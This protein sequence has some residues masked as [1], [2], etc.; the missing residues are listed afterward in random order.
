MSCIGRFL[1]LTLPTCTG[2][3][4]HGAPSWKPLFNGKDFSGFYSWVDGRGKNNDSA[5]VFSIQDST[6][7]VYK[8]AVAGSLQPFAYLST[9]KEYSRYR[10][11]L[12]FKWGI[13]KFSPRQNSPRDAG[14]LFHIVLPDQDNWPRCT[15]FQ[16]IENNVGD[17]YAI[18]QVWVKSTVDPKSIGSGLTPLFM[19]ADQGGIPFE[20]PGFNSYQ[21]LIRSG[22]YEVAGWNDLELE[23]TDD[24]ATY[25]VNGHIVNRIFGIQQ[26][27]T[28]NPLSLKILNKGKIALQAEDAEVSYRHIEILDLL[29]T[30]SA[31]AIKSNSKSCQKKSIQLSKTQRHNILGRRSLKTNL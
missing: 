7:N 13:N 11:R 26:A 8:G 17:I 20:N 16:I 25:R 2:L 31:V 3:L 10:L 24:P 22:N 29:D 15:E 21:Q 6:I 23:V 27:I 14:L 18:R 9:L 1:F 30:T 12:Q 19:E 28:V 5:H 4:A